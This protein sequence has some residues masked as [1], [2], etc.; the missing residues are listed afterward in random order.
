LVESWDPCRICGS[1]QLR[2]LHVYRNRRKLSQEK[3][4]ALLGCEACGVVHSS[5]APTQDELDAYYTEPEGWEAR[6]PED[7]AILREKLERNRTG[8]AQH[9]DLLRGYLRPTGANPSPRVFD[10]GCGLGTWLDVLQDAGWDTCGLEPG[11][12]QA[13]V[14]GRRHRMVDAI[15]EQEVFDL[16]ILNHVLEHLLDPLAILREIAASVLPGGQ[17]YVSVPDFGTVHKHKRLAYVANDLH[18]NSFSFSGLQ[19]LL[20]LA[21]FEIHA[22]LPGWATGDG[23]PTRM[24]VLAQRS[25]RVSFPAEERPLDQAIGSLREL[26]RIESRQAATR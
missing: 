13:E 9:L 25:E 19:S 7:E 22:H 12:K 4:L 21:G 14:A 8:Y 11:A 20:A 2:A 5:P 6:T 26:G 18:I 3:F 17:V 23:P 16:A 1:T 10:F 15:P 24:R